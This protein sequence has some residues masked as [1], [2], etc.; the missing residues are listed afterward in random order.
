MEAVTIRIYVLD[1]AGMPVD[2]QEELGLEHVGG[3]VPQA[4]D[5]ILDSGVLSGLDRYD[6]TNR[7]IWTVVRRLFN[8]ADNPD[9]VALIVTRREGRYEDRWM[10]NV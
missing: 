5:E 8:P 6:I 2:T 4:G 1:D 7:R 9:Y 3:V 10:L